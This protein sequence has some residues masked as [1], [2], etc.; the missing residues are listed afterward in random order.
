MITLPITP[1]TL[2]RR[3][4]VAVALT[5]AGFPVASASL[6]TMA[7]RGGG[8]AFRRFGRTVLYRWGEALEWAESKLGPALHSTPKS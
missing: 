2:L 3:K 4:Q 8:P 7:S 5:A 6:A 1:E